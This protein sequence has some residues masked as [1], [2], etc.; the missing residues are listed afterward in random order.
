MIYER[1]LTDGTWAIRENVLEKFLFDKKPWM[2]LGNAIII[3]TICAHALHIHFIHSGIVSDSGAPHWATSPR[4]SDAK[5][6]SKIDYYFETDLK[7][8]QN[9]ERSLSSQ[10][11]LWAAFWAVLKVSHHQTAH[12]EKKYSHSLL[13]LDSLSTIWKHEKCKFRDGCLKKNE[14]IFV[15]VLKTRI[16][17]WNWD[18]KL[19]I[20]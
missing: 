16:Y 8:L 14:Y 6:C 4:K 1:R 17:A 5:V 9:G 12:T 3:Q 18:F 20:T 15:R 10:N 7:F 2:I 13:K 19:T 11:C